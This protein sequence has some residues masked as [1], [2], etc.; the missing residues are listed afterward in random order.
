M[1]S[2][3]ANPTPDA[4]LSRAIAEATAAL[5]LVSD[6][7]GAAFSA[8]LPAVTGSGNA[9]ASL[10]WAD[11]VLSLT[12]HRPTET[13]VAIAFAEAGPALVERLGSDEIEEL[14]ALVRILPARPAMV[15]HG[16]LATASSALPALAPP[17]RL[18]VLR[19][20]RQI[21]EANPWSIGQFL[22]L[23]AAVAPRLEPDS[24]MVFIESLLPL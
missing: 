1:T 15:V 3:S 23:V 10:R 9:D 7:L 16:A 2:T 20:A 11:E 8:A 14:A 24:Q 17:V 6:A 13:D 19:V 22:E 5:G 12:R 4:R 21:A 18:Q